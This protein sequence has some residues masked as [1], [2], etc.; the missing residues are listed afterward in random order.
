MDFFESFAGVFLAL[1]VKEFYDIFIKKYIKNI[2]TNY[3]FLIHKTTR[4]IKK[5]VKL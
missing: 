5:K 1:M 4:K 2:L 3:H